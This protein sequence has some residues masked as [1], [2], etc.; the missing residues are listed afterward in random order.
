MAAKAVWTSNSNVIMIYSFS[1]A[2]P[3]AGV[4]V[5]YHNNGAKVKRGAGQ[6]L[7]AVVPGSRARRCRCWIQGAGIRARAVLVLVRRVPGAGC[8]GCR[9]WIL[10][11]CRG[12][13][14][15]ENFGRWV[16]CVIGVWWRCLVSWMCVDDWCGS[17]CHKICKAKISY[18]CGRLRYPQSSSS[19]C[20]WGASGFT[21]FP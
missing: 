21:S 7:R 14:V 3:V 20:G 10:A 1:S 2:G 19:F 15:G 8:A 9:V 6:Y 16:L 5:L 17:P 4:L 11:G 12:A 13:G 18:K